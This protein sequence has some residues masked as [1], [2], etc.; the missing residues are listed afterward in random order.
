MCKTRWVFGPNKINKK[1]IIY[2]ITL[3]KSCSVWDSK[4][5]QPGF[6]ESMGNLE[7]HVLVHGW[8]SQ[9]PN[10][11]LRDF[12]TTPQRE[13]PLLPHVKGFRIG[14]GRKN[15]ERIPVV[16]V[17]LLGVEH[18]NACAFFSWRFTMGQIIII[19]T[20]AYTSWESLWTPKTYL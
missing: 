19:K 11:N 17:Q 9:I 12:T 8:F 18:P 10:P 7:G 2:D 3:E 14:R 1:L 13:D 6:H 4:K 16:T 5:Q 20:T 15:V